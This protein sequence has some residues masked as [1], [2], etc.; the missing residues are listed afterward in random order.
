MP[1]TKIDLQAYLRNRNVL[2]TSLVTELSNDER[3]LAAWLTGSYGR[4]EADAVSD[5]D[6]TVVIAAPH[7][8][9]LCARQEQVSHT[10][11]VERL[12]LF[13][14]FG[15]PA[16]IHEN[17]HNAPEHGTFTF[18][19]YEKS[20]LMVDWVLVPAIHVERPFYSL[21][22]FDKG[23]IAVSAPPAPEE[24]E[25]S[26]KT[27]AERWAFFWM[28]AAV[29]TKYII[30][31]DLVSA[32]AWLEQLFWVIREIERRIERV[33]QGQSYQRGSLSQIQP[34]RE[35]QTETLNELC[36]RMRELAPRVT[37]FTGVTLTDPS[38]E[39]DTLLALNNE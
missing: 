9:V 28:M 25:E 10:T 27:V 13:S 15:Q 16:V 31:G 18:V 20:A 22:L 24:L 21:L 19:L 26:K 11:T 1:D 34:T 7:H 36:Q 23:N 12:A 6:L 5:L 38:A 14:R 2:I 30:R 33:P 8:A 32:Q 35:K 37:Q 4:N 29:T 17:N 39:I 3:I